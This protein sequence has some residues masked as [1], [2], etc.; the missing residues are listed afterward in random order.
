MA[1][2]HPGRFGEE[3]R[4]NRQQMR[5][6]WYV[7]FRLR[8]VRIC[9]QFQQLRF[10]PQ[11][12]ARLEPGLGLWQEDIGPVIETLKRPGVK[13]RFGLLPIGPRNQQFKQFGRAGLQSAGT[14]TGAY[15]KQDGCIG[16]DF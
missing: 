8:R 11:A 10:H 3:I 7:V 15:R 16:A 14:D 12:V 2:P 1:V 9:G 13:R 5:R 4:R 6:S